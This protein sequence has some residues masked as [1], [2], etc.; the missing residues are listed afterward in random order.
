MSPGKRPPAPSTD[1][2]ESLADGI[3]G[4]AM[5]LLVL[6]LS[7]P[8]SA[9]STNEI[10]SKLLLGQVRNFYTYILSFLLLGSLWATHHRQH[11]FIIRTDVVHVWLNIFLLM[12]V[13]LV[14][15]TT[16]LLSDFGNT[17][18]GEVIF[19][20]NLFILGLLFIFIWIHATRYHRLIDDDLDDA[21]IAGMTKRLLVLPAAPLAVLI[22]S[23]FLPSYA[24]LLYVLMP[25]LYWGPVF[26]RRRRR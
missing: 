5:T 21:A 24:S 3:F 2:V 13:A 12:F 8:G 16:T 18:L 10:L 11:H 19:A 15:F 25:I 20:L 4:F 26:Q 7:L 9:G 14:P 6:N 23:P 17:A 22:V 1:R